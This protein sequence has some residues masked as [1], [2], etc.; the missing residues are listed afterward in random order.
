M[1]QAVGAV[2]VHFLGEQVGVDAGMHGHERLTKTGR[3]VA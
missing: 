1:S 3:E 2:L